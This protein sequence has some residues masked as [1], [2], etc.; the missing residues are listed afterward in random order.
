[1]KV[2][3]IVLHPTSEKHLE[4][5]LQYPTHAVLLSGPLGI[6]KTIIAADLAKQLLQVETLENQAYFRVVKPVKGVILIEQIRELIG[7][8]Q[9][10]VPGKG[11]I[12]RVAIIEDAETMG[13]EAQNALLKQLEEPP[14]DS[15]LILTASEPQQLLPT[16]RSRTQIV[17]LASPSSED[18]KKNFVGSGYDEKTVAAALLRSGTNVAEAT[19]LLVSPSEDTVLSLVKQV[20]GG[21]SYDRLLM[22]DS[23][24]K[25]KD[26]AAEFVSTLAT[27]SM[28]S[29]EAA[30]SR[31]ATSVER[32]KNILQASH[33]AQQAFDRNGN[34][35]IVLTELMLAL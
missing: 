14:T 22:V 27:V 9:L 6:G 17:M 3:G 4:Q 30:A 2:P 16:I 20:L 8:F 31:G 18:L 15:V 19:K 33:I 35:K 23:L 7:F 26:N 21:T 34:A 25:Q 28:A 11:A 1:M 12:K 5:V 29:L 24:S 32:W 10:K 13:R